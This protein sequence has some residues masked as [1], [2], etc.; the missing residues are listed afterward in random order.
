MPS[1]FLIDEIITSPQEIVEE[2]KIS[3]CLNWD[4]VQKMKLDF[5]RGQHLDYL[6]SLQNKTKWK[7]TINNFKIGDVAI[8]KEDNVPPSVWPLGKVIATHAGKDEL[9]SEFRCIHHI[10]WT[11]HQQISMF[12]LQC[13]ASFVIR[14]WHQEQIVRINY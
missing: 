4:I 13:K 12:F 3:L 7:I 9:I 11:W 2:D 14:N 5:W 10:V 8:I 6:S 1:H